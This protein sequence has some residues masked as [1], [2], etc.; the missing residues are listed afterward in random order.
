M[1]TL[2]VAG[3]VKR[4]SIYLQWGHTYCILLS[5]SKPW[6]LKEKSRPKEHLLFRRME[7]NEPI[8]RTERCD[9][10]FSAK[11]IKQLFFSFSFFFQVFNPHTF[12][13]KLF[14]LAVPSHD[15]I[16]FIF[17]SYL[18]ALFNL[19]STSLAFIL[20]EVVALLAW[21]HGLLKPINYWTSLIITKSLEIWPAIHLE[22]PSN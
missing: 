22:N 13:L 15:L 2:F 9:D 20:H 11:G 6:S 14:L 19:F 18:L 17:T 1:Y 8:K 7:L 3:E 4:G 12:R 5:F 16:L 10:C 21:V